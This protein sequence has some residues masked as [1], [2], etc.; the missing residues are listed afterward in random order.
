MND[1]IVDA[2]DNHQKSIRIIRSKV[3]TLAISCLVIFTA[4]PVLLIFG[5]S[6]PVIFTTSF[7]IFI[8]IIQ[9]GFVTPVI[10]TLILIGNLVD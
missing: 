1:G 7:R 6:Y 4:M 9:A 2:L 3:L 8:E 10:M 5:A